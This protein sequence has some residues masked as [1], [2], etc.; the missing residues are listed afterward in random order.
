MTHVL[1]NLSQGGWGKR[2]LSARMTGMTSLKNDDGST[3][4]LTQDIA[5]AAAQYYGSL[6]APSIP[7]DDDNNSGYGG[8]VND[9][10]GASY[11]LWEYDIQIT[12]DMIFDATRTCPKSKTTGRDRIAAEMWEAAMTTHTQ[13]AAAFAW[14]MNEDLMNY[15]TTTDTSTR[16]NRLDSTKDR[17]EQPVT[18]SDYRE[19]PTW[20]ST[21]T[22]TTTR[23]TA[24]GD[25]TAR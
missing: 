5:K 6:F 7:D 22:P 12:A 25:L 10:I 20:S 2:A 13:V 23:A 3:T 14:A 16:H 18:G 21:Y 4:T 19:T 1:G 17:R 24:G 11:D 9:L 8:M 15:A